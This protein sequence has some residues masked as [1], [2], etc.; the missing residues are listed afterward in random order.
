M[1]RVRVP[2]ASLI[3][4]ADLPI[5]PFL[6]PRVFAESPITRRSGPQNGRGDAAQKEKKKTS[7]CLQGP[8]RIESADETRGIQQ[9][10]GRWQKEWNRPNLVNHLYADISTFARQHA[11]SYATTTSGKRSAGA[12]P[13]RRRV[14]P[15]LTHRTASVLVRNAPLRAANRNKVLN[16]ERSRL[17]NYISRMP[18]GLSLDEL[19]KGGRYRSLSR[20]VSNLLRWDSTRLDLNRA[21]HGPARKLR[22][23]TAFAALDRA[24]YDSLQKYT[25]K[26]VIRHH[27]QCV[28]LSHKL[29][30]LFTPVDT[31]ELWTSWLELD[32]GTRKTYAHRLL[33]YL[34]DR[35]PG[36]AVRFIQ[37]L[38]NDPL[39]R[40]QKK[41]AIADALGHLSKVHTKKLYGSH[42]RWGGDPVRHRQSFVPA[43]VHIFEKAL[44]GHGQRDV[45]SQDL[46]YNLVELAETDDLK[47]LFDCLVKHRTHIGF[48][49]M[50]HY[51]SA[52]GEAGEVE[53]ALECLHQLRKRYT[54]VAWEAMLERERLRWTCAAI[55]RKSM[56]TSH[57]FHQTPSVVAALV[58]LGI[59]MNILLYNIV[60]HNAMEA[61]DY[62]TAFQVYNALES[63]DLEPDKHTY[64]ILLHGCTLQSNPAMFERFAQHCSEV[65][66]EIKDPWL[67]TDYLYYLYVRHRID[68]EAEHSSVL[69]WDAYSKHF[70]LAPL[71]PFVASGMM[72]PSY[73]HDENTLDSTLLPPPPVALYLMLQVEIR[74][75]LAMSN[76][77]V[78]N[79]YQRFK[80][81]AAEG[82]GP[83]WTSLVHNPTIWNA[84]LLAFCGKQQFANASQ[85]ISDM[86][87]GPVQPNIYT[88]NIFMQSFFKTGQVQA[89]E[90]VF[91]IMRN[92][93]TDPDQFTYGVLL[94]GYAKAQLMERI[95]EAMNLVE[96]EQELEPDL[97]RALASVVNRRQLM[98]TLEKS[99]LYKEKRAQEETDRKAK[100]ERT[101][102]QPPLFDAADVVAADANRDQSGE[103]DTAAAPQ[104]KDPSTASMAP[105]ATQDTEDED[106]FGFLRDEAADPSDASPIANR[107]TTASPVSEQPIQQPGKPKSRPKYIAPNQLDP[108]TQYRKLQEQLGLVE[109]AESSHVAH[110]PEPQRP[111]GASLDFKS[112]LDSSKGINKA[113]ASK[114][115]SRPKTKRQRLDRPSLATPKE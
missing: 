8:K 85:L 25:R 48:D 96:T 70:S 67:A 28:Q 23:N 21:V 100:D 89:A 42:K 80:S 24:L 83:A 58:H 2:N 6:A 40:G 10:P 45:C 33:I 99:R 17:S 37:V 57:D 59:K 62:S 71:K 97:L 22:L 79:L 26:M 16:L 13:S 36:R 75:A 101:R 91:E 18:S 72:N 88:W 9:K 90:R 61:G 110:P 29:F 108:E 55:L 69:L 20:R 1:P 66:K 93:G 53:Y 31:H 106:V 104:T 30:P 86:T 47:R 64:S 39:L 44:A 60:M 76:Q 81:V 19:M 50:L 114:G 111:L 92:R 115:R 41:E 12:S 73:E 52:F 98:L 54:A 43:F 63:N 14:R 11:R 78:F 74:S 107:S 84:F 56:S 4:S 87:D 102:W 65:A 15:A 51:A 27:P 109:P 82:G 103:A 77:R 46:L 68:T 112:L 5:L 38:S 105:A 95:G 32:V 94:R 35:K 34:L 3:A 49:T 113:S 7:G